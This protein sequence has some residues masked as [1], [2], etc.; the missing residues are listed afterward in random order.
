MTVSSPV[1]DRS[2]REEEAPVGNSRGPRSRPHEKRAALGFLTPSAIGLTLF[3]L[4]PTILAIATSFF[5]WPT[6]GDVT[7]AGWDNYRNLFARG[8]AFPAALINTIVFTIVVVPLNLVLTLAMAFWISTSRI[9]HVYR[10][11]FF[12]PVVTPSVA[13]SIIWKMLY[14]PGGIIDYLAQSVGIQMPNLLA[15]NST[16]LMAVVLVV[17]WNGLGYNTLIFSAAIDQLPDSVLDAA[18]IDGAG[19]WSTLFRVK[20]PLMT[21]AIFFAT[22]ITIIQ[23]F[24]IFNQ[25]YVMTAGGPGNATVTVVMDVYQ[26]AFQGG[27]LGAAAAPAMILFALILVVTALQWLGQKKWVSYDQ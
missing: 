14:Q 24:Q 3:V 18:K 15:T 10:V 26:K 22:T 20:L 8:N 5:H 6:F 9:S 7:F 25:P 21:P 17:I 13:T 4:V 23:A 1:R 2:V 19:F 27:Q 11:L 12:L 16:A